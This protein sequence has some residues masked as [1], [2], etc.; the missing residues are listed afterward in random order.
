[1]TAKVERGVCVPW[2]LELQETLIS[3]G[4]VCHTTSVRGNL[5]VAGQIR[6][7]SG[8]TNRGAVGH[9]TASQKFE[10]YYK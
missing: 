10:V 9:T 1:M 6:T 5:G 2:Y 4:A 8:E 3:L 7:A